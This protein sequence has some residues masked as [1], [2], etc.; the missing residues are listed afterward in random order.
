MPVIGPCVV[1]FF[2]DH[3]SA[4][5]AEGLLHQT[6]IPRSRLRPSGDSGTHGHAGTAFPWAGEAWASGAEGETM[7]VPASGAPEAVFPSSSFSLESGESGWAWRRPGWLVIA[8]TDGSD[9]QVERAV[10]IIK[11]H[12]GAI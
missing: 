5:A 1:G 12:G 10:K 4:R 8:D 9:A 2:P 6:G 11:L 7:D 3:Y